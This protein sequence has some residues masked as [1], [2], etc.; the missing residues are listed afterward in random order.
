M[1]NLSIKNV[2]ADVVAKLRLRAKIHRR[3]LQG[4][5]LNLVCRATE[6]GD[7]ADG[8]L[9]REEE[10]SGRLSIEE[11]VAEFELSGADSS[12]SAPLAV[13]VIRQDRDS[14]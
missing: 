2:P 1:P 6:E 3:S 14:R 9:R 8:W 5:V 13:D 11:V 12:N 7:W 10:V 4:E